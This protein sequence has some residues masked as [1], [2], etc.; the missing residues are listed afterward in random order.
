MLKEYATKEDTIAFLLSLGFTKVTEDFYD[1][2]GVDVYGPI[3]QVYVYECSN[4]YYCVDADG[5]FK[6]PVVWS[7][8][9]AD[10]D[11]SD[12]GQDFITHLDKY[13]P[14]WR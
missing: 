12:P 4:G 2:P 5:G 11:T 8:P 7:G 6:A 14:N 10:W 9:K 13:F 1:S 3:V